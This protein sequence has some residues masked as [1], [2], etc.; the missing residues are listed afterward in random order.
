MTAF[1]SFELVRREVKK[2]EDQAELAQSASEASA[3]DARALKKSV[4]QQSQE[5]SALAKDVK[6]EV[7]AV[8]EASAA[9]TADM[10]AV[11]TKLATVEKHL[12]ALSQRSIDEDYMMTQLSALQERY[13]AEL[14]KCREDCEAMV[15]RKQ[16]EIDAL[17]AKLRTMENAVRAEIATADQ[18][19]ADKV[20]KVSERVE[21][22]KRSHHPGFQEVH[23]QL[24]A[25]VEALKDQI[26]AVERNLDDVRALSEEQ[27]RVPPPPPPMAHPD[28]PPTV[29]LEA[30][31]AVEDQLRGMGSDMDV[32][33]DQIY[34]VQRDLNDVRAFTEEQQRLP[35]PPRP[36]PRPIVPI[37]AFQA[38]ESQLRRM[39]GDVHV[40]AGDFK[41]LTNHVDIQVGKLHEQFSR[42]LQDLGAELSSSLSRD[43][44]SH[45]A[46]IL[47]LKDALFDMQGDVRTVRRTVRRLEEQPVRR[48]PPRGYEYGQRRYEE[49]YRYEPER[50]PPPYDRGAAGFS[51]HGNPRPGRRRSRSRSR[52]RSPGRQR[53]QLGY[54]NAPVYD[55]HPPAPQGWDQSRS[56]EQDQ[57]PVSADDRG[58]RETGNY[59]AMPAADIASVNRIA[60]SESAEANEAPAQ[61][62][63]EQTRSSSEANTWE[64]PTGFPHRVRP[65]RR[66]QPE[67]IVIEEE[68]EDEAQADVPPNMAP[69]DVV[70]ED[71]DGFNREEPDAGGDEAYNTVSPSPSD[72]KMHSMGDLNTGLLL[73]FC[74]GGAPNLDAA[75]TSHFYQLR[76]DECV[77]MPRAL[78]FQRHHRFLQTLP[79]Y[80]TQCVIQSVVVNASANS[81]SDDETSTRVEDLEPAVV[82]ARFGNL[83]AEIR[84]EWTNAV[85]QYL[86]KE[87]AAAGENDKTLFVSVNPTVISATGPGDGTTGLAVDWLKRQSRALLSLVRARGGGSGMQTLDRNF[88]A[89]P[90]VYLLALMFDVV[91]VNTGIP[92]LVS[93]RLNAFG[94]KM[95]M[96]LWGL[97]LARLPYLF[98]A[99]WTWLEDQSEPKGEIPPLG[100]CHLLATILASNSLVD[101]ASLSSEGIH[102][103]AIELLF[104]ALHVNGQS[105]SALS[106][107]SDLPEQ[108]LP[109]GRADS[110]S[111]EL[112]N[113]DQKFVTMLAL[114]GCVDVC[115]AISGAMS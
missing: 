34:A 1:S 99:D 83:V 54:R 44:N 71:D 42:R 115:D 23:E 2:A 91:R 114:D 66:Q 108:C 39:S 33:K 80:L 13:D 67:V 46:E 37:E 75:W 14:A 97:L 20:V 90:A 73:Y 47:R 61:Q 58:D 81:A 9:A 62:S 105:L 87:L 56:F 24:Q 55:Q 19:Q 70:L 109:I 98:F 65:P 103:G 88:G 28:P 100:F 82:S 22:L 113:L 49:Q 29:P 17:E 31:K 57:Y 48:S 53:R 5:V 26:Y 95:V 96:H 72:A 74:L 93:L 106:E 51:T 25:D 59:S 52:S 85:S 41:R 21:E 32:L 64:A 3:A 111:I 92:Q 36:D 102:K 78:S 27:Q 16:R 40:V 68:D 12:E 4:E 110:A 10:D 89:S 60:D 11:K 69:P 38:V 50:Q 18:Q 94:A 79:M 112:I 101:N 84:L 15:K 104:R 35:P 30:M 6:K 7:R 45:A 77:E 8:G 107:S 86:D 63:A 76:N 43:T